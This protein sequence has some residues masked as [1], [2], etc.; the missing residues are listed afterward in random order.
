MSNS[1]ISD[2]KKSLSEAAS[3]GIL[4]TEK[5]KETITTAS[6]ILHKQLDDSSLESTTKNIVSGAI[7]S[8]RNKGADTSKNSEQTNS[9][10]VI[11]MHGINLDDKQDIEDIKQNIDTSFNNLNKIQSDEQNV[12]ISSQVEQIIKNT[13]DKLSSLDRS[14]EKAFTKLSTIVLTSAVKFS[15]INEA[16]SHKFLN[17]VMQSIINTSHDF[18][19][20]YSAHELNQNLDPIYVESIKKASRFASDDV[21]EHLFDILA[22]SISETSLK[23]REGMVEHFQQVAHESFDKSIDVMEGP[24]KMGAY[25]V[26]EP[27]T[28]GASIGQEGL[29]LAQKAITSIAKGA[30]KGAK[31]SIKKVSDV[32]QE[33]QPEKPIQKLDIKTTTDLGDVEIHATYKED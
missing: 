1:K 17:S 14:D 23:V 4:S 13:F 29:S 26:K 16:I 6:E 18:F 2:L 20:K 30:F 33:V 21:R 8:F 22:Q 7:N 24:F 3:L 32:K 31:E 9:V 10:D 11:N 25:L 19:S 27:L 15:N 28:I 12:T 5:L